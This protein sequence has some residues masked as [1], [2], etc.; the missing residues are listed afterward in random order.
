M[1][2]SAETEQSVMALVAEE[3]RERFVPHAF[4]NVAAV[5]DLLGGLEPEWP[6][7]GPW[8]ERRMGREQKSRVRALRSCLRRAGLLA[9]VR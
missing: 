1:P 6:N 3:E 5:A 4:D 9:D 2:G 8:G 7:P